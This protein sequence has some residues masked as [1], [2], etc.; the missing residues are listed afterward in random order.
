[1]NYMDTSKYIIVIGDKFSSLRH[2]ISCKTF[3]EWQAEKNSVQEGTYYIP[4]L[5][6]N[7]REHNEVINNLPEPLKKS[8]VIFP[9]TTEQTHK[10]FKENVL[11]GNFEYLSDSNYR[12]KLVINDKNELL[13]DHVTGIHLPGMIFVEATRQMCV[14]AVHSFSKSKND[15]LVIDEITSNFISYAYPLPTEI[16]MDIEKDAD[17]DIVKYN[18]QVNFYQSERA[19]AKTSGSFMIMEK[20]KFQSTEE[21]GVA[22]SIKKLI[23]VLNHR[24]D[25]ETC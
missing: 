17:S 3:L 18:V 25:H 11:L 22:I 2:A 13:Q 21:R 15:Y 9:A 7:D 4:G 19:I 14:A 8:L 12:A 24:K 23:K 6:L 10:H 20:E 5:G 1:M 16:T